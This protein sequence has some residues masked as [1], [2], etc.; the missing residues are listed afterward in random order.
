M[1]ANDKKVGPVVQTP[2]KMT[3]KCFRCNDPLNLYDISKYST[4]QI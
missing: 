2:K 1:A 3:M 4:E